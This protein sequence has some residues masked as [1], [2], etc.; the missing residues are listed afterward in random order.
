ML[1]DQLLQ[2]VHIE[3][4]VFVTLIGKISSKRFSHGRIV[5]IVTR[6]SQQLLGLAVHNTDGELDWNGT[7]IL[8]T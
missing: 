2:S 6:H 8:D 1:I 7:L 4:R 3:K 5:N